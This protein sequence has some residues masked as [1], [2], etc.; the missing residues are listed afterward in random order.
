MMSYYNDCQNP[1]FLLS[2]TLPI[3]F[4][5]PLDVI[6]NDFSIQDI[7]DDCEIDDS[8]HDKYLTKLEL[9]CELEEMVTKKNNVKLEN[10]IKE[11]EEEYSGLLEEFS[12][13]LDK[14]IKDASLK[15]RMSVQ[16][17]ELLTD[18]VDINTDDTI[19]QD[20]T[21][22]QLEQEEEE[23]KKKKRTKKEYIPDRTYNLRP[24]K[25]I[26]YVY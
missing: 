22:I 14:I 6:V 18:L 2:T 24:R 25:P 26:S 23:E 5:K 7:Q 20:D 12:K 8:V 3:Q 13:M 9:D 17:I 11:T 15:N 1:F 10:L 4:N 21:T 16:E 19:I